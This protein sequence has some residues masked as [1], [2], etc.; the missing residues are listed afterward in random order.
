MKWQV[1]NFSYLEYSNAFLIKQAEEE[2]KI[3]KEEYRAYKLDAEKKI[4][5]LQF[6]LA[7]LEEQNNLLE[8]S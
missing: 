6:D 2:F 4:K 1:S 8:T 5:V 7:N 3:I